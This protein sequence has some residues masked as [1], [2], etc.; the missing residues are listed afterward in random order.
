MAFEVDF[1]DEF[2][3]QILG[4]MPSASYDSLRPRMSRKTDRFFDTEFDSILRDF[5]GRSATALREGRLPDESFVEF[6]EDPNFFERR[7]AAASPS[8]RNDFSSRLLAPSI[9]FSRTLR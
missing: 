1:G 4:D 6:L 7:R 8:E 2:L 5:Q 9:S 3:K